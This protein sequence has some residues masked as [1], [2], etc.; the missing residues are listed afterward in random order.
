MFNIG[1]QGQ[2]IAGSVA[3]VGVGAGLDGVPGLVHIVLAVL[4]A[5]VAGAL[6]AAS[7]AG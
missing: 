3:A 5:A 6:W 7:R 2:Y 4:A 1:G